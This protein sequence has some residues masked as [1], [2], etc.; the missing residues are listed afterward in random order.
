VTYAPRFDRRVDLDV[1]LQLALPGA[2]EFGL[3]FNFG[4]GIP[5][6]RP[7]AQ[8]IWWEYDPVSHGYRPSSAF[9]D[10]S[11]TPPLMVVLGPRNGERYPAYHRADVSLRRSFDKGRVKATP[12]LQV[13]NVYNRKNP[14]FYFFDYSGSPATM[15]GVTMFPVLPTIGVEVSF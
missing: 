9:N 11:G 13:L 15:S 1:V 12:Y 14:L 3:R 10:D 4:T 8:H 5:Y 6:T 2:T 7:V